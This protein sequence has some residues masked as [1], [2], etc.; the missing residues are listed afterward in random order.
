MKGGAVVAV[1]PGGLVL[2]A[3]TTG[4]GGRRGGGARGR[5]VSFSQQSRRR[6]MRLMMRIDWEAIAGRAYFVT[7][8]YPEHYP[9]DGRVWKKNLRAFLRRL[10]RRGLQGAVWRLEFQERGAPHFHL[11]LIFSDRVDLCWLREYVSGAWYEVVGS[12]DEKHLAAGTNCQRVRVGRGL[13]S[14]IAKYLAKEL[15]DGAT[16]GR[17]WGVVG[18]LPAATYAVFSLDYRGWV[19]FCRRVRRWGE[20]SRYLRSLTVK[21]RGCCLFVAPALLRGLAGRVVVYDARALSFV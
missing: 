21:R 2:K 4:S 10:E 20:V 19:E 8:T 17:R 16:V 12:G 15:V 11:L 18:E 6:L 5:I 7:L 14:Y 13:M 1:Y 3:A 9:D